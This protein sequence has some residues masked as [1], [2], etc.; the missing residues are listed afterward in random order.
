MKNFDSLPFMVV[1][2]HEIQYN[3]NSERSTEVMEVPWKKKTAWR[4]RLGRN[5]TILGEKIREA[6]ASVVPITAI[7]VILSFTVAPLPTATLMA[8]LIGAALLIVGMGLFTLGADTAM[9]PIGERVGAHMTRSRKLWVVVLVG[10]LIGVIVTVS[11][12]DLQVLATQVPG[13]PNAML[14]GAVALGVGV[15]LVIAL[16]RILFRIPLNRMLIVFYIAIFGLTLLVPEDFLAIAFDSGGVTTGPMTVPF[17]MALGLGVSSI[18][19][20]ENAS[21]DSFGLVALCSVGPILAVLILAMIF[22]AAGAYTPVTAPDV[23]DSR[24]LW[25]LFEE[26]FPTYFE[27]VA[28]CLAPIAAFFAVFQVISLK[29]K[30]K[31]VLKIL[32]GILYTDLGLVLFLTGVNVGFMP[33]GSY[34]GRQIA[35]LSYHWILIPIGM[36]M[37]WFIVQAEP[38]VHVLNKQVE[39]ITS[40]AIPGKAMSTSLSVGVAVSIG[41]AMVRVITG[42]SIYAFLVPGYLAAIVMSFFVPKIFTA[43]AFDSGGVASGP[44]TATFLLPFAMGACEALGGNVV[45]DA[46]GVVA[47]VAMTPLLTIQLLGLLYQS[48]LR[49]TQ[50][51]ADAE[52]EEIIEL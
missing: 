5:R 29:L 8:F 21:Q 25:Q 1:L 6:L 9:T 14:I 18:R 22:P 41:L 38:A 13:V 36:L 35:G 48:K 27:E 12:P 10:F 4:E 28:I 37:G 17:I 16:L 30:R 46:F 33:A 42:V 26:G 44:M 45:T 11:E 23:A 51:Q 31:K 47:M 34:L 24:A 2:L 49:R 50:R 7:V 39:E 40:G 52:D 43:I 3:K 20:D 19:S 32:V 15:F